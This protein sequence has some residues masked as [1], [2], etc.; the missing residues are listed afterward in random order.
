LDLS[1]FGLGVRQLDK[2]DRLDFKKPRTVD[3]LR[4]ALKQLEEKFLQR[5]ATSPCLGRERTAGRFR[6]AVNLEGNHESHPATDGLQPA[7]VSN[8]D[9]ARL[10]ADSCSRAAKFAEPLRRVVAPSQTGD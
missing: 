1:A 7:D 3:L 2:V 6:D 9:P 8:R 10:I 5:F 4:L